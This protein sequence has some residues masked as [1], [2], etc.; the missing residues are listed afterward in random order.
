MSLFFNSERI[1]LAHFSKSLK[2][3][4]IKAVLKRKSGKPYKRENEKKK[5]N[6]SE[7][8]VSI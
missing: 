7:I 5:K 1:F 3:R 8:C 2:F 6:V 4:S